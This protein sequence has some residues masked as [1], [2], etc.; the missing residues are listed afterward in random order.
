MAVRVSDRWL[1]S[2]PTGVAGLRGGQPPM[3]GEHSPYQGHNLSRAVPA[4]Y[5]VAPP[6]P[7]P[8]PAP[9]GPSGLPSAAPI[10]APAVAPRFA[11]LDLPQGSIST[12]RPSDKGTPRGH[13]VSDEKT[14]WSGGCV[15]SPS[16]H[17]TPAWKRT[18]PAGQRTAGGCAPSAPGRWTLFWP[19]PCE[20]RAPSGVGRPSGGP[21]SAALTASGSSM[22]PRHHGGPARAD[23]QLHCRRG[24]PTADATPAL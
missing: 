7:A 10:V 21:T 20:R 8:T 9:T 19:R 22:L 3:N 23:W 2:S 12:G 13:R 15:A 18:V 11:C 6:N 4:R 24:W 5:P 1:V 17:P 14:A 16:N